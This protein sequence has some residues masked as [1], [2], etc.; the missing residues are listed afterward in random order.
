MPKRRERVAPPPAKDGWDFRYAT[1]DA[2]D[3]WE[4]IGRSAPANLRVAWERIIADPRTR[5][6][7]PSSFRAGPDVPSNATIVNSPIG[8]SRNSSDRSGTLLGGRSETR[9]AQVGANRAGL[10]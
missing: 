8:A 10:H 6:P 9:L 2:V 1:S 5:L 7:M 4:L 3:G